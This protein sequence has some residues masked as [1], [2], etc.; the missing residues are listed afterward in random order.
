MISDLIVTFFSYLIEIY[1]IKKLVSAH[2]NKQLKKGI[3]TQREFTISQ[4]TGQG[5][6]VSN[7]K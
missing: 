7:N 6:L 5:D 3:H 2:I 4:Q 1:I